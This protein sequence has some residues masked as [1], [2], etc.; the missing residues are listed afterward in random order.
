MNVGL[1]GHDGGMFHRPKRKPDRSS[2][3]GQSS[4]HI[5]QGNLTGMTAL[6]PIKKA[7]VIGAG[8]MGLGIA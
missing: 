8:Q 5:Q 3:D 2:W 7:A 1:R 6:A 4:C